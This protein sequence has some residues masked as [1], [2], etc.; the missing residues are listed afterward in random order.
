MATHQS[1]GCRV[2]QRRGPQLPPSAHASGTHCNLQ[3][4]PPPSLFSWVWEPETPP[5]S[6]RNAQSNVGRERRKVKET[7]TQ[8][9]REGV[10]GGRER[11]E[12]TGERHGP[13][14]VKIKHG[15][16]DEKNK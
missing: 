9:M 5:S 15:M 4:L 1:T 10:R 14:G 6:L 11:K 8:G 3:Q 13:E 12:N 7:E 16:R 2:R